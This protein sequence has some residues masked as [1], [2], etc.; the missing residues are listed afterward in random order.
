[1]FSALTYSFSISE[2][3]TSTAIVGKV[4]ATDPDDGDAVTL[5]ILSGNEGG[6]FA[7][8]TNAT[9][10]PI[11]LVSTLDYETTPGYTLTIEASDGNGG[12]AAATVEITVTDVAEGGGSLPPQDLTARPTL[13][14]VAPYWKPPNDSTIT[15]YKNLRNR[16]IEDELHVHAGNT[17]ITDTKS[18]Y[19]D[20]RDVE[21]NTTSTYRVLSINGADVGWRSNYARTV[22]G[23]PA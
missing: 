3:A 7:L 21:P 12:T 13:T 4:S 10:T 15:G 9:S 16:L 5:S 23:P 17:R 19:D 11:L 20:R 6:V 2:N 1:M 14:L 8:G 22:K 18:K